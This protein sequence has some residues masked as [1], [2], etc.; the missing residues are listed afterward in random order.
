MKPTLLV[1]AAGMG[2]RYGGLKQLD[3]FGPNG[4]T[5]MDYSVYD[6]LKA[7]FGKVVF[8]IRHDFAD[9]F[10][11][12]VAS[13]YE[14]KIPV[15]LVYQSLDNIPQGFTLNTERTKP[16]GTGHAVWCATESL[17]GAP[18]AVINADDFYGPSAF[19]LMAE[20]LSKMD[21][22]CLS[23]QMMVGYRLTNTLS[24]NGHVSR[25]VCE[26]NE[27]HTL[28]S[29]TERT[30]IYTNEKGNVVF[31]EDDVEYPLTGREVVSMNMMGF[32]SCA[33]K[34]FDAD[35]RAFLAENAAEMKKEFYL[36]T[37][38][39]NL[40]QRGH[41][42]VDVLPTEEQWYGVTYPEDKASVIASIGE[43]VKKGIYPSPLWK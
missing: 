16:L 28:K 11:E 3:G 18:F 14:N 42:C 27:D 40:I 24:E 4:E 22:N 13:K 2:S 35:L 34:H 10:K 30:K 39:N 19:K 12:K 33:L 37:V 36:P 26:L 31:I 9:E 41:S 5:I 8:V 15:E 38:L 1:L 7:G 29:I 17:K 25:G 32:S 21:D 20:Y 23:R 6:A 43:M